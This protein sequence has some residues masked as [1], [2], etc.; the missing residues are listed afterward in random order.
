MTLKIFI[1]HEK[2]HDEEKNQISKEYQN[3]TEGRRK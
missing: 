3:K 1:K 2:I